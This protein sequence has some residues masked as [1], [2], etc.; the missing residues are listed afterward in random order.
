[1][2]Y[3]SN[4]EKKVGKLVSYRTSCYKTYNYTELVAILNTLVYVNSHL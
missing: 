4:K 3:I 2:F 1:M